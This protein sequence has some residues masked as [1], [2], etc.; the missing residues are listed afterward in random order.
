MWSAR[1]SWCRVN[2]WNGILATWIGELKAAEWDKSQQLGAYNDDLLK[3]MG[4]SEF[5]V[6]SGG[7][8]A[9]HAETAQSDAIVIP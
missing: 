3:L 5:T 8:L 6:V 7:Q 1:S 9:E 4:G 2:V